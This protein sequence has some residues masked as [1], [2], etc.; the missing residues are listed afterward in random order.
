[1]SYVLWQPFC[2]GLLCALQL[3]H[4]N[5]CLFLAFLI[6]ITACH[7]IILVLLISSL[8]E[9]W[10]RFCEGMDAEAELHRY[11]SLVNTCLSLIVSLSHL[12]TMRNIR[13]ST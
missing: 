10:Q 3:T 4:L 12:A 2:L 7:V 1:M 8:Q 13:V 11:S 6:I 9:M 5:E